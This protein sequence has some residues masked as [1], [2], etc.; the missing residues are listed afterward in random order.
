MIALDKSSSPRLR[1]SFMDFYPNKFPSCNLA[2]E[3]D[4]NCDFQTEYDETEL[5]KIQL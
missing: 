3:L 5:Q 2:F 1:T 4:P